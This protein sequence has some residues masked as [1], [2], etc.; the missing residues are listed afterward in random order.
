MAR[1]VDVVV[2]GSG[3]AGLSAALAARELGASVLL[4]ERAPRDWAGGNSHFT[5]GAFRT[6]YAG[7]D[8]LRPVLPELTDEQAET[9]DLPAY[10]PDDFLADLQRVTLRRADPVLSRILVDD[11]AEAVRWLARQG[12]RWELLYHRQSFP[13]DGRIRFWGNL[14]VGAIGGG[15]GLVEAELAAAEQAGVEIRYGTR[16]VGFHREDG[17]IRGVECEP[18]GGVT[19]RISAGAVVLACG[20]FEADARMRATYLGPGW[21]LA[22]VRGTPYNT[23]DGL[24]MALDAGAAPFGHWSGCHAIAWDAD[25]PPSGDRVLTNRFSRQAYPFGLVVN[26]AGRR[27]VDEG[28]DFRNYTYAKYGAEILRQPGAYAWQLFDARTIGYTGEID[29]GTAATS[30][31]E[32]RTVRELA[33]Q[34]GA[35][36][37]GLEATIEAFNAG[38]QDGPFDPTI[39]DGKH[40]AGIEPPKSNWA[41][42]LEQPPFVAFAVTCGITFTFGG[43]RV[44]PDTQVLRA[45]GDPIGDVFACGEMVGGIFFH[46]YPGGS[47]LTSGTVFGRRAGRSAAHA[48]LGE[49]E[50]LAAST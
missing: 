32:A 37:D 25:A 29:Y 21:D 19:E 49:S 28:A 50:A 27:F 23:G 44:S 14:T 24:T 17:Q 15:A 13:V 40:T 41:L 1:D 31:F 12:V 22:K 33:E 35:D 6:T 47:G 26:Q 9:I 4:L 11:A 2:V 7:L 39:K 48:A 46:N 5:A 43:V 36:P 20:G 10:A 45:D 3:N 8:D 30:R 34:I 42:P 38:V 16:V 18:A